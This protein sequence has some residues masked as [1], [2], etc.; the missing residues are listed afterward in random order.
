MMMMTTMMNVLHKAPVNSHSKFHVSVQ[1][2]LS[3]L[4]APKATLKK[5]V[6]EKK[7]GFIF[8][9]LSGEYKG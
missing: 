3:L 7:R 4:A 2:T 1:M 6:G 5:R 9:L 8:Q